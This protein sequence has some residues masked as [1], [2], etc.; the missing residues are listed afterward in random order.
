MSA[1]PIRPHIS[2]PPNIVIDLPLQ[3]VLDGHFR[4][5]RRE[6]CDGSLVERA[7]LGRRVD[8]EFR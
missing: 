6:G 4:Q 8:A 7:D 2:E 1:S 3:I 5:F